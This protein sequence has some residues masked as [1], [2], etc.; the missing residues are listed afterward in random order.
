MIKKTYIP[1]YLNIARAYRSVQVQDISL[2]RTSVGATGVASFRTA[3]A[4]AI[5]NE[6]GAFGPATA[7]SVLIDS[8]L[9]ADFVSQ[10][11]VFQFG[12][13]V[14]PGAAQPVTTPRSGI[15]QEDQAAQIGG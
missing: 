9:G 2:A 14:P 13:Q 3:Q 15:S 7:K 4:G 12:S 5:V 8:S 6:V 11:G 1:G 10:A